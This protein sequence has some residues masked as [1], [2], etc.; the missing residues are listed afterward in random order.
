MPIQRDIYPIA[1]ENGF[2]SISL[3]W[4][5]KDSGPCGDI[6]TVIVCTLTFCG[7][8]GCSIS[9]FLSNFSYSISHRN[10]HRFL[11]CEHKRNWPE[12]LIQCAK[13]SQFAFQHFWRTTN[14][15]WDLQN[16][17]PPSP[18]AIDID[19]SRCKCCDAS[20]SLSQRCY[21]LTAVRY[22]NKPYTT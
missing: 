2:S 15:L 13:W 19:P 10:F 17:S 3:A 16:L 20:L 5:R 7:Y 1:L 22:V 6:N 12:T 9:F 11:L 18:S 8:C 21:R 4:C 14:K